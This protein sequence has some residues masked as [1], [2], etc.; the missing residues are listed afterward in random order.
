MTITPEFIEKLRDRISLSSII[1]KRVKL[2]K[3]GNRFIGLCPFHSEKTPSFNVNDDEGFFYCF[4]C[5]ASGD[6]INYVR[7]TSGLSFIESVQ[8]LADIA[9]I[10]MPEFRPQDNA[11]KERNVTLLSCF[12]TA[13]EFFQKSLKSD[14]GH[15]ALNYL[16]QR[17]RKS[18][19][20]Y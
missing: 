18:S 1:G 17:G 12:E 14:R 3:R 9:G 5:G 8:E 16:I 20:N 11:K 13:A 7:E 4:G 19:L 10:P 15:K 6:V 2:T